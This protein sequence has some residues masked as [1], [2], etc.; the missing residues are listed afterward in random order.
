[1]ATVRQAKPLYELLIEQGVI[2][3]EQLQAAQARAAKT[4]QPLKRTIVQEGLM[5]EE[6]LTALVASQ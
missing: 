3:R 1:M 2:S 6:D 4:G 5:T